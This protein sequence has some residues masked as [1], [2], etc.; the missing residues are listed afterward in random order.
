MDCGHGILHGSLQHMKLDSFIAL[1][2]QDIIVVLSDVIE[3]RCKLYAGVYE[4]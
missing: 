1:V 3:Y 4:A 2:F